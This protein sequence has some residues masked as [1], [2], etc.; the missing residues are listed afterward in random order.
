MQDL[1]F[2]LRRLLQQP[3]FTLTALLTLA[4]CMGANLTLFAVID[5][6]LLRE[7]PFPNADRLVTTFNSY[8]QAGVERSGSSIRDYFTRRGQIDAFESVSAARFSAETVGDAGSTERLEIA[9][10]TPEFFDTLD[11]PLAM[12]R[13]FD[14]AAMTP[15][16][17]RY[18][19]LTDAYWREQLNADPNVLGRLITVAGMPRTVVGVL[20]PNFRYLSS[21]ARLYLPLASNEE[22]R[23]LNALHAEQT[24]MI[25]RLKPGVTPEQALAQVQAHHAEQS[26][27]YPWAKEVAAAGF[28]LNLVP[29][30]ADHVAA[31]RPVLWLLQAGVVMLL[32]IGTVNLVNLCLVRASAREREF[33]VR[34]ALGASRARML[35]QVLLE[36]LVLTAGGAVLG[37]LVGWAGLRL[38]GWIGAAQL[39]LAGEIAISARMVVVALFGAIALGVV[40]AMPVV[41]FNARLPLAGALQSQTR[42][43]SAGQAAG[44]WR[45]GFIVAQIALAFVLLVGSALLLRGFEQA[46]RASP[47]FR[48]DG[49]FTAEISLPGA[50]YGND[51]ARVDA[52]LRLTQALARQPGIARAGLST[53]VPVRGK[54]AFN[55]ANAMTVIGYTRPAGVSPL[56]HYRY[57]VTGDYFAAMGIELLQGRAIS[58]DDVRQSRRVAVVDEDFAR[59]YWPNGQVLGQRFFEGPEGVDTRDESRAFTVIGVTRAVKQTEITADTGNGTVYYPYG[60]LAN[61]IVYLIARGPAD[62][63]ATAAAIRAATRDVDPRLAT[64]AVRDMPARIADTLVT[65]R[66]PALLAAMFSLAALLLSGV[67]TFGV[68]SYAVAQR[69]RE[70]GMRMALGARPAQIRNQ[71]LGM[72]L[73]LLAWGVAIGVVGIW[74]LD[75]VARHL[76]SDLPPLNAST[77]FATAAV[78]TIMGIAASL[79]PALRAMHVAPAR[80]LTGD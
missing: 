19:V 29:L 34:Q 65:R 40:I 79:W 53:N 58:E 69:R 18:V 2:A 49:V 33:G 13:M 61:P 78:L 7:L 22:Q 37:L 43:S 24:E 27:G 57:G 74:S 20:P 77:L 50:D 30:H 5:G 38:L 28:H 26:R 8:P 54:D 56:L 42:G 46:L 31:V 3:G 59:F 55:D 1:R 41:I 67:G 10:V 23:G 66:S 47:G 36:T 72:A 6:V 21:A 76:Q 25:A 75:G 71:F 52:A 14:D 60:F 32:L 17:D 64:S 9:R 68:L 12:G 35:R 16:A 11:V 51:A 45:Q 44:R 4:L 48:P 15:G 73:R 63:T 62:S 80:V 39:P 70:V